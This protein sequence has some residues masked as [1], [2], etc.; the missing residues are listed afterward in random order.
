MVSAIRREGVCYVLRR[1]LELAASGTASVAGYMYFRLFKSRRHF[2]LTGRR[3]RY[4]YRWY[5][6][7]WRNER[8]VEVPLVWERVR[9]H[10]GD[11]ILEIG[12]VL[13]HYFRVEHEVVDKFEAADGV[14]NEDIVTVDLGKR[15]D[16][17]VS[18]STIEH[19][20]WNENKYLG[21][22]RTETTPDPGRILAAVENITRHLAPGGTFM[23]TVPVGYSPYMDEVLTEGRLPL[24]DMLCLRR[25][26]RD[27]RWEAVAW[28]DVLGLR[29]DAPYTGAS[30]VVVGVIHG[31]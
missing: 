26:S 24:D 15:Y 28:E 27:N 6:R 22:G 8:C 17:I 25:C 12:N 7:T 11:R 16:L 29:F 5:N 9:E 1:A 20:G 2:A 23:F 10:S 31:N 19:L 13:G 3:F 4:L 18:I 14:L 30:G 21:D